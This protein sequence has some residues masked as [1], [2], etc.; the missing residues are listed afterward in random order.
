MHPVSVEVFEDTLF[1]ALYNE[2][3]YAINK[4]GH[5]NETNVLDTYHRTSDL[6][7]LHPLK[8]NYNSKQLMI[9]YLLYALLISDP[10]FFCLVSNPCLKNP[11]PNQHV[12]LLSSSD[13]NGRVCKCPSNLVSV[14]DPDLVSF[15]LLFFWIL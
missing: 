15:L 11:C 7:M 6:F 10:F 14:S 3:I 1:A 4:F 13:E 8:Q 12:C 9:C 2:Q 5:D